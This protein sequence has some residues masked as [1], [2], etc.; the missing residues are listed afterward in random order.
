[1]TKKVSPAGLREI[2]EYV[3]REME[4][5]RI[6]RDIGHAL[7]N[8]LETVALAADP[9]VALQGEWTPARVLHLASAEVIDALCRLLNAA[10]SEAA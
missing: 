6:P 8:K 9:P 3:S 1:M 7:I 4:N 10:Q 2:E 5:G